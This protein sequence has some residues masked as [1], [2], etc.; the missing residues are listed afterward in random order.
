MSS[1]FDNVMLITRDITARKIVKESLIESN[2]RLNTLLK[3]SPDSILVINQKLQILYSNAYDRMEAKL[4]SD[5]LSVLENMD[6]VFHEPFESSFWDAVNN[7][8]TL[9]FDYK[10]KQ[11]KW[12]ETRIAQM[13]VSS[14]AKCAML[15]NRDMTDRKKVEELRKQSQH[16]LE[17]R[18]N[19][20]NAEL[21]QTYQQLIQRDK[22]TTL[23][24]LVSSI[25]HEINNPNSFI[26]F[27]IPILKDYITDILPVLDKHAG[28]NE[29]YEICGLPYDEFREDVIN[30]LSN[31]QHGSQRINDTVANLRDF[32]GAQQEKGFKSV[33]LKTLIEKGVELCRNKIN[34]RVQ[35][36]EMEIPNETLII[37][38]VPQSLEQILVNFLINAAQSV[39]KN[40]SWI[41][42]VV[43]NTHKPDWIAI[44]VQDNGCGI[45]PDHLHRIFD[46]F[47][48]TKKKQ[49]GLGLGLNITKKLAE[50]IGGQIEVDS[51]PGVGSCFRL[52]V[53]IQQQKR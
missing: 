24:F 49:S 42:L 14:D 44:E 26:S 3:N 21:E 32:I 34:S 15:I 29:E 9:S 53:P 20:R 40:D 23:G 28:E 13:T 17:R 19:E 45:K 4:V 38:T 30:L 22:M 46:P 36:F 16:E 11:G 39:D 47:F 7:R 43:S 50:E 12:W 27:N 1:S 31:M 52:L 48:T 37:S 18:I 6:P 5:K 33:E 41:K 10:D 2:E 51:K 8:K 25:A 35:R